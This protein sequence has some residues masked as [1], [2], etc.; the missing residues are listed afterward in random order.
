[1]YYPERKHALHYVYIASHYWTDVGS[2]FFNNHLSPSVHG[3][4]AH[5]FGDARLHV[6]TALIKRSL[7]SMEP[8]GNNLYRRTKL[9][10]AEDRFI[11]FF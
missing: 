1:M 10:R 2:C 8:L 5:C 4:K 7:S 11:T 6:W 9:P 3:R